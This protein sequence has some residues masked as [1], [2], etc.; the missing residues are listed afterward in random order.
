MDYK[1]ELQ[2]KLDRLYLGYLS[3]ISEHSIIMDN[4][5]NELLSGPLFIDLDV[6]L[7]DGLAQDLGHILKASQVGAKIYLA[8]PATQHDQ[9]VAQCAAN[10]VR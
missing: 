8:I 2:D 9:F 10:N 1:L 6:C 5:R 3:N 4:L 7:S